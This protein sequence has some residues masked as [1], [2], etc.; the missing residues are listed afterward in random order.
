MCVVVLG[1]DGGGMGK[2]YLTNETYADS[3]RDVISEKFIIVEFWA[4]WSKADSL[5]LSEL[6]ELDIEFKY[7]KVNVDLEPELV[8]SLHI[9]SIPTILIYMHG[10]E[11]FRS[12]AD[13]LFEQNFE[14]EDAKKSVKQFEKSIHEEP[15]K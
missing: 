5:D 13:I 1:G 10:E 7:F 9:E 11:I 2:K 8:D 6:G 12:E 4:I 15:E 3:T 14:Q